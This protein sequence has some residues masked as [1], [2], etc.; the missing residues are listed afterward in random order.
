MKKVIL[1]TLF[2]CLNL[3]AFS[4]VRFKI[5]VGGVYNE[6]GRCV[7]ET[8]DTNYITIG[9]TGSFGAGNSD[10]YFVKCDSLGTTYV[11]KT[12][13]SPMIEQAYWFEETYDHNLIITGYTNNT[14]ANGYDLY[15]VKANEHGDKI[16][17]KTIGGTDWDFG[18]CVQE[19]PADSGYIIGG[20]TYSYG[21]GNADMYLIKTDRNGDTLWTRT[22]GGTDDDELKSVK[23]TSD[24]GFILAGYTKS[25]KDADGDVYLVKTNS[26]GDTLWTRTYGDTAIEIAHDVVESINGGYIIGGETQ[27]FGHTKTGIYV[28]RTNP[29]GDPTWTR[30]NSPVAQKKIV[31]SLAEESDGTIAFTGTMDVY[32]G[33]N[34]DGLF[35]RYDALGNYTGT[36]ASFE[37]TGVGT[38]Q[39]EELFSITLTHDKGYIMCGYTDTIYSG[40]GSYPNVFILKLDSNE[41]KPSYFYTFVAPEINPLVAAEVYPNPLNEN[42]TMTLESSKP[43]NDNTTLVI[44]DMLGR[45]AS[46]FFNLTRSGINK[47]SINSEA[48]AGIYSITI[49]ENGNAIGRINFSVVR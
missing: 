5:T 33:G 2:V 27:S 19:N 49:L 4:Q 18:Y 40:F 28:I 47:Y 35:F 21:K 6:Y 22:Y 1:I 41:T 43:F 30:S 12:I 44:T 25:F 26:V 32:L 9:S 14:T 15:L 36:W 31:N 20:T 45:N 17:E 34:L 42:G 10:I 48:P 11:K 13:G 8:Y 16:W 23:P 46:G 38:L 24:G 37:G 29:S 3:L 39:D 7:R